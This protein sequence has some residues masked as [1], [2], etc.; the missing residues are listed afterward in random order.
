MS[1]ISFF[2]HSIILPSGKYIIIPSPL[3]IIV[4]KPKERHISLIA[5]CDFFKIFAGINHLVFG[6][7]SERFD[8]RTISTNNSFF[9]VISLSY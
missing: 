1:G 5:K 9:C 2:S 8:L 3:I 6:F 7:I 4:E